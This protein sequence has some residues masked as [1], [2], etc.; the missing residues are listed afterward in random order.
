MEHFCH[1]V[2]LLFQR[3]VCATDIG[4]NVVNTDQASTTEV[5]AAR[6][7]ALHL[8]CLHI[9]LSTGGGLSEFWKISG[10]VGKVQLGSG[11]KNCDFFST[12]ICKF[13]TYEVMCAQN[14]KIAP[15]IYKVGDMKI[16]FSNR[17]KFRGG[18]LPSATTPLW[19]M[20]C[21]FYCCFET[22]KNKCT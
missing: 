8:Q 2:L 12:S 6:S 7:T 11:A 18:A 10:I 22:V 5:N 16:K 4:A 15:K 20:N 21:M 14:F 19:K 1:V 9:R 3:S 13:P 17:L